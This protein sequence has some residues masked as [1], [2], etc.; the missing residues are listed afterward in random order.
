MFWVFPLKHASG[1]GAV[2]GQFSGGGPFAFGSH[3]GI[4]MNGIV[5]NWSDHDLCVREREGEK[6]KEIC[7][8]GVASR[9]GGGKSDERTWI[10][11]GW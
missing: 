4:A 5:S 8:V 10:R 6:E 9:L 3:C 1:M 11:K 2:V 7:G